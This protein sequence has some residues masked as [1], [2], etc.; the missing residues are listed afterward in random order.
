[1]EFIKFAA[2]MRIIGICERI[3]QLNQAQ[4]EPERESSPKLVS[5]KLLCALLT[6][7]N[8]QVS[9]IL[10]LFKYREDPSFRGFLE[11]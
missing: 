8:I 7:M 5:V 1:M 3:L 9:V 4:A 11:I 2:L 6:E 10:L